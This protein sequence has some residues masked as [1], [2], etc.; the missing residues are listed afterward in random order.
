MGEAHRTRRGPGLR[1]GRVQ[2]VA[3]EEV[4]AQGHQHAVGAVVPG[5]EERLRDAR[6]G[7]LHGVR[8]AAAGPAAA[9]EGLEGAQVAGRAHQADLGAAGAEQGVERVEHHGAT[10]HGQQVLGG[11]VGEGGEA[12]AASPGEQESAPHRARP[13]RW[14]V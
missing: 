3:Q 2:A 9:E 7:G 14:P 6:G 13:R 4:V 5:E 12:R 1:Q 10:R 8:D 11:G